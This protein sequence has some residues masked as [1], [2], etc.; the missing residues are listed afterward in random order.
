YQD[1]EQYGEGKMRYA[2]WSGDEG[3]EYKSEIKAVYNL[4]E[5]KDGS[6]LKIIC[7]SPSGREGVSF[8][9]VQQMHIMEPY[10]NLQP[11]HQIIGRAVIYCSHKNLHLLFHW[12][13]NILF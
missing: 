3:L 11:L 6:K 12:D 1:Y 10:W 5:N 4:I 8:Y 2:V 7:L 9:N 13:L